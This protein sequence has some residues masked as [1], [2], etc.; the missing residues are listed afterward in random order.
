VVGRAVVGTAEVA[1]AVVVCTAVVGTALVVGTAVVAG[2][3][4]GCVIAG[5]TRPEVDAFAW[6]TL[7]LSTFSDFITATSV[8]LAGVVKAFCALISSEEVNCIPKRSSPATLSLLFLG[9]RGN[10]EEPPCL[11][12]E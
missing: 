2:T 4:V 5:S 8:G 12:W 6:R 9:Q 3:V 11:N 7:P 10:Q 1:G